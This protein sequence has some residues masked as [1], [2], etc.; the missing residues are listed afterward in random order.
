VIAA[1]LINCLCAGGDTESTIV[2]DGI[3]QAFEEFTSSPRSHVK[4]ILPQQQT[5]ETQEEETM[6]AL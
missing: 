6:A 5:S 4:V 1:K 2:T 3:P